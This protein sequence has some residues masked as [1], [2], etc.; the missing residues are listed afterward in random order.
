MRLYLRTSM[1][2]DQ[3]QSV[4][5]EKVEQEQEVQPTPFHEQESSSGV[6]FPT[7]GGEKK[8]GG[9]KTFL[10]V[11][12]LILVAILGFVIYNSASKKSANTSSEATPFDNLTTPSSDQTVQTVTPA[13]SAA[14]AVDK[15]KIKVQVQN[16][17]GISG[18]AA[19]LQTQLGKLGYT[20]IKTGNSDAVVTTA[21]VTFSSTLDSGVVTEI[22]QKL[23]SIYQTVTSNTST[24]GTFDVV[25]VTGLQKGATPKPVASPTDVPSASPSA[26]P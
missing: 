20:N 8:S 23:N 16:G 17:T 4:E 14:P 7:V 9:A 10:I 22:T 2:Q 1:E 24:S 18:E 12:I 13:P 15:A 21:T 26:T 11:G 6:S 25:V 19:Y 3:N 5:Q